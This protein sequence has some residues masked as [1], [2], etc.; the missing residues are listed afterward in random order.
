MPAFLARKLHSLTWAH[1]QTKKKLFGEKLGTYVGEHVQN[2]RK[3]LERKNSLSFKLHFL[4]SKQKKEFPFHIHLFECYIM[5]QMKLQITWLNFFKI[6]S[7]ALEIVSA[8]QLAL[9]IWATLEKK[10]ILTITS[11]SKI[12]ISS[13][14][15]APYQ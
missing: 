15:I 10:N 5:N 2:T 1:A 11:T 3:L 9:Q 7:I 6:R 13:W 12:C 4:T 8:Q 14:D